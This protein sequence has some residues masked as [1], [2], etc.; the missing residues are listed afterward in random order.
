MRDL[1]DLTVTQI[2]IFPADTI[3]LS[4]LR[5]SQCIKV[6]KEA[7][8]F[9]TVQPD[10]LGVQLG[11]TN[12][13]FENAGKTFNIL[14]LIIDP[15]RI[16]IQ[17]RAGSPIIDA[18]YSSL[19]KVLESTKQVTMGGIRPL[20]KAEETTC[21]ATLDIEFE[22]LLAPSLAAFLVGE[23]KAKLRAEYGEVKSIAF[24]SLS[25]EIKYAP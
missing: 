8:Q 14:S 18:F 1:V 2:R 4:D 12:G 19:M 5:L 17:A 11:F 9:S 16:Q 21:V 15:R 24:K 25:F 3:P 23:G 6:V 22:E 20:V 13:A 7:F 10:F